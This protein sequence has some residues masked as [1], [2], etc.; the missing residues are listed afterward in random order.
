MRLYSVCARRVW[1]IFFGL[2]VC[3]VGVSIVGGIVCH[4]FF[5]VIGF[6]PSGCAVCVSYAFFSVIGFGLSGCA[7]GVSYAFFGVIGFGLS[8]CAVGVSIV[9]GS[10]CYAWVFVIGCSK[11][12]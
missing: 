7:V 11:T 6:G 9:G 5:G 4:A 12:S 2:S 1:F 3:A 10:V 8:G